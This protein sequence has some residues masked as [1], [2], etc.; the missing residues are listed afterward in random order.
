MPVSQTIQRWIEAFQLNDPRLEGLH[1]TLFS[2]FLSKFNMITEDALTDYCNE[3]VIE[4]RVNDKTKD[5]SKRI[6][7]LLD[8]KN[9]LL[10]TQDTINHTLESKISQIDNLQQNISDYQT[11]LSNERLNTSILIEEAV[12]KNE[13]NNKAH[14]ETLKDQYKDSKDQYEDTRNQYEEQI[15]ELKKDKEVLSAAVTSQGTSS[16][17]KGVEGEDKLIDILANSKEFSLLD[18]HNENHKG[19]AVITRNN[20]SYS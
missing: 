7:K 12:L 20:K 17:D 15:I 1:Y 19:D 13:H 14:I 2:N 3:E 9:K 6:Q 11:T 10:E 4:K 18:T 5:S 8:D 16:Y